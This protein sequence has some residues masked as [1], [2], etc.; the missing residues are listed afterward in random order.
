MT[1]PLIITSRSLRREPRSE[2]PIVPKHIWSESTI[3][4]E[5]PNDEGD[6]SRLWPVPMKSYSQNQSIELVANPNFW[7]GA[8]K[9]DRIQYV[10]YT[11]SDAMVQALRAGE[12]DIMT[13]LTPTQFDALE[14]AGQCHDSLRSKG[15]VTRRSR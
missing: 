4:V 6:V 3:P 1:A 5:Y 2:I 9:F 11:N 10:Y 15:V 14:G 8:P 12:V 13:G 7:R